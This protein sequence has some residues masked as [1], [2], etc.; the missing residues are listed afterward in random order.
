MNNQQLYRDRCNDPRKRAAWK[1]SGLVRI[2]SL[3][4]GD[5]FEC[6]DG[7][8]WQF[9]SFNRS[10]TV[11]TRMWGNLSDSAESGPADFVSSAMIRPVIRKE[12]IEI[13]V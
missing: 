2:D 11:H 10:G 9:D 12:F 6:V 4:R 5:V 1:A 13:E 7:T 3:H 8:Y